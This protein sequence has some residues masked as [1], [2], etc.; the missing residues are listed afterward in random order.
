M[1]SKAKN[2]IVLA[3][4]VLITLALIGSI[5]MYWIVDIAMRRSS[6]IAARQAPAGWMDSIRMYAQVEPEVLALALPRTEDGNPSLIL[7]GADTGDYW[8]APEH[9]TEAFNA[10]TTGR[11]PTTDEAAAWRAV[12]ADTSLD[13]YVR[14]ARQRRWA[15]LEIAISRSDTAV[16]HNVFQLWIPRFVSTKAVAYGLVIRSRMRLERG[17]RARALEDVRA[18]IGLGEHMARREPTLIGNLIGRVIVSYG[19]NE[20]AHYA[21]ITRDTALARRAAV[22]KAWAKGRY[23]GV[24]RV[25]AVSPDSALVI[26]RDT[27]LALGWRGEAMVSLIT[28]RRA[29]GL[30]FGVPGAVIERLESLGQDP[31]PEFARLAQMMVATARWIN[32]LGPRGRF[33][34]LQSVSG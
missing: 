32:D 31:D 9:L 11:Q 25:L 18:A 8:R 16:A 34:F 17:D 22:A 1:A 15:S 14:A 2:L 24:F 19:A 29:R 28:F 33:R 23:G 21:E 30:L 5:V 27:A 4:V 26:A 10:L 7:L 20:L 12:L 6:E 3:G 13:R